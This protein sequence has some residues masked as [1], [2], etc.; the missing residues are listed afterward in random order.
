MKYIVA[1]AAFALLTGAALAEEGEGMRMGAVTDTA[2]KSECGACHIAYPAGFLP[3]RSWQAIMGDLGKHFG[4]D[5]SLTPDVAAGIEAY[6]VA[7]AA[8]AGGSSRLLRGVGAKDTPLR[9]S[10]LPWFTRKHSNE[11]S[12]ARLKKAGSWSNCQSCHQGADKGLFED[13]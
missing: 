5:A 10:E 11:V 9:I 4:E 8:D 1:A 3:A 13:D 12:P 7:N 2:T 6:L